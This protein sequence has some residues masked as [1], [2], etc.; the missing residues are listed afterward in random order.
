[1]LFGVRGL[2]SPTTRQIGLI[3]CDMQL[4][5]WLVEKKEGEKG[6]DEVSKKQQM[7]SSSEG[8]GLEPTV[9]ETSKQQHYL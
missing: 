7:T 2:F 8:P 1:M 9:C 3:V 5:F 6:C 4:Y